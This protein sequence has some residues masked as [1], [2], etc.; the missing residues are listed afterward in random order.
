MNCGAGCT[1]KQARAPPAEHVEE[2]HEALRGERGQVV[3]V[4][5]QVGERGER[6]GVQVHVAQRGQ[7]VVRGAQ[8][9]DD[10]QAACGAGNPAVRAFEC[11]S[12]CSAARLACAVRSSRMTSRLPAGRQTLQLGL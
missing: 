5:R 4:G 3:R 7:V 6:V 12:V 2:R 1:A 8:Q 10:Q 11:L 9:Q